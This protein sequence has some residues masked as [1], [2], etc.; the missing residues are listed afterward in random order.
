MK[1]QCFDEGTIQA[2]LDGELASELLEQVARHV[3]L[4]DDCAMLLAETEEE[5]AFAFAALEDEFNSLVP[6]ER[7]RTNLY[8]AISE[9]EKPKVSFWEKITSL[10]FV[11]SNPSLA[12]FAGLLVVAG[13]FAVVWKSNYQTVAP[14]TDVARTMTVNQTPSDNPVVSQNKT[15]E[16]NAPILPPTIAQ[17][18]SRP[19]TVNADYRPQYQNAKYTIENKRPEVKKDI[20]Q[21]APA[22]LVAGESTYIKTIDT[23]SKTVD[24]NKGVILGASARVAY[25]KDMAMVNDAIAK[26]KT[27]VRKNPKNEVAKEVL[28]NSYQNKIDLM[29]SVAEQS[30]MVAGLD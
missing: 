9:I 13:L 21:P 11:F 18:A 25:E 28:R 4:C 2:F 19:R 26:M 3:A 23:L 17:T 1:E 15:G 6:T 10:R 24:A 29:N 22:E 30:Q 14:T 20:V 7:I 27:E 16:I 5:S 12:A 8:Q